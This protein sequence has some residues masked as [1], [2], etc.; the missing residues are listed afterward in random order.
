M[1]SCA[2]ISGHP[3]LVDKLFLTQEINDAGVFQ[4]KLCVAGMW[5]TFTLDNYF[6]CNVYGGKVNFS[7]RLSISGFPYRSPPSEKFGHFQGGGSVQNP[8]P[9]SACG[10]LFKK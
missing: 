9:S 3:D 5:E 10:G 1:S 2:A 6:P 7:T 4:V 8:D